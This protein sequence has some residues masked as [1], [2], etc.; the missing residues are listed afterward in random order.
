MENEVLSNKSPLFGRRTC[1]L[2]ITP[3]TYLETAR[4]NPELSPADNAEVYAITGGVPH[5][6]NK[7]DVRGCKNEI[8]TALKENFFDPASYLFEEPGNLLRQELREPATYNAIITA[9]ANGH[10]RLSDIATVTGMG[11]S[12]CAQYVNTLIEIGIISKLEPVVCRS[13]RKTQYRITDQFFRFWYR[14]V[15]A[16]NMS[17]ASG[18]ISRLFDAAVGSYMN[19]YMGLPFEEICRQYLIYYA[20]DLPFIISEIGE[21]WGSIPVISE[22]NEKR[23][24]EA[25]LD[26]VA[27]S[28]KT[29]NYHGGRD[30]IIGSCKYTGEAVGISELLLIQ[31]YAAAFTSANDSCYY[32]LFSKNGFAADLIER[33]NSDKKV[34]LVTLEDMYAM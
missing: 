34:K 21:W 8:D 2:K 7:L 16:N 3:L 1:Q 15:P 22:K 29:N 25:Q 28:A 6:I 19:Q 13:K 27:V 30:Y 11:S 33:E 10:N 9:I 12:S 32:W 31:K 17:I 23:N 26:I 18:T 14:F 24:E 20:E 5:Y 4:F